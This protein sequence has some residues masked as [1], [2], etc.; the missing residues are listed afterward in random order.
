MNIS[1]HIFSDWANWTE[2]Q[3]EIMAFFGI[4][5]S[6]ILLHIIGFCITVGCCKLYWFLKEKK[7]KTL[8]STSLSTNGLLNMIEKNY[9]EFYEKGLKRGFDEGFNYA[10]EEQEEDFEDILNKTFE[11]LIEK[12]IMTKHG[13]HLIIDIERYTEYMMKEH[14]NR[15]EK[16]SKN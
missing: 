11:G 10:M 15:V 13:N 16:E 5:S 2:Y 1:S 9:Q 8:N 3:K 14:P 12:D 4:F 7:N 6:C